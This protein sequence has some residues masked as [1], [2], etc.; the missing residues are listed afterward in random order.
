MLEKKKPRAAPVRL[1]MAQ[2]VE[3]NA[4]MAANLPKLGNSSAPQ[5]AE[6]A[7][8]A[9]GYPVADNSVRQLGPALGLVFKRTGGVDTKQAKRFNQVQQQLAQVHRVLEA[10]VVCCPTADADTDVQQALAS[11]RQ[12]LRLVEVE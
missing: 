3:L 1:S 5:I 4:W 10:L 11:L 2:V 12:S 8:K 6:A 7:A 9:L